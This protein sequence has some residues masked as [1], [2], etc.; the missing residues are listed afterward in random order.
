[1]IHSHRGSEL[2][3]DITAVINLDQRKWC[4]NWSDYQSYGNRWGIVHHNAVKHTSRFSSSVQYDSIWFSSFL[5]YANYMY[6]IVKRIVI[7][8]TSSGIVD[9][10]WFFNTRM[11][12][13]ILDLWIWFIIKTHNTNGVRYEIC[14]LNFSYIRPLSKLPQYAHEIHRPN[15]ALDPVSVSDIWTDIWSNCCP[16]PSEI[17][18]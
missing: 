8:A 9:L 1:M 12:N 13:L 7:P 2:C 4:C 15:D 10:R 5:I 14:V 18:K 17:S 11:G 6:W 3:T 16:V